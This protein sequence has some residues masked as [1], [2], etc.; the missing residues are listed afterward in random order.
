MSFP[1]PQPPTEY[2]SDPRLF[3]YCCDFSSTAIE[4]VQTNS[5]YDPS[6]SVVA[7]KVQKALNRLS[8]LLKPGGMMFLQDYGR[9]DMAQLRFKKGCSPA[10]HHSFVGEKLQST[11]G[12]CLSENFYVRGDGS[13]VYFFTQVESTAGLEKVQ[14]L[15]D[16]RLQVNRGK[17]L[18]MYRVWIQCKYRKPLLSNTYRETPAPDITTLIVDAYGKIRSQVELEVRDLPEELSLSFNATCLNNEVIPGLKSCVGLK[19][20]DTVSE[21]HCPDQRANPSAANR[22]SASVASVSATPV[23][24]AR[25]RASTVSATTS[26]SDARGRC[27]RANNPLYKEATS[28]FTNTTYRGT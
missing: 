21:L 3:V 11:K 28:T 13:R 24:L 6:R 1:Y 27:A 15:V 7:D 26:V 2:S 10:K 22:A 19:I 23:T 17:Q 20:G 25:S 14:N 8:R 18:T 16:H 9:Y 4:L 12:Q 5:A